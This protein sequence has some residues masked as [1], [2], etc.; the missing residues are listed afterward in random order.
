MSGKIILSTAYLPPIE[1]YA[2]IKKA[3]EILIENEENYVKQSYRNRFIILS[4]DR[5][6]T[7]IVPVYH[8]SI[9]KTPIRNIRIDYSKRWQQVHLGALATS[10][11][12]S[13]FFLY[14]FETFEKIILSGNEFLLDLNMALLEATMKLMNMSRKISFT[15]S[16]MPPE[17]NENDFRY[18]ISPKIIS[19]YNYRSY[20]QVFNSGKVF[21]PGLSIADLLFNMG[22]EAQ[23]YL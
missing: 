16:F 2:R 19:S 1:Y 18:L 9:H 6:C 3:D 10:Y 21:T 11:G 20:P 7:L 23:E 12:S 15:R 5:P 13:P 22:P 17:E 8:G 4:A 14:Y